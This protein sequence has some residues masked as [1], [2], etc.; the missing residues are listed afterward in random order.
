ME[1]DA[2]VAPEG[3]AEAAVFEPRAALPMR[4]RSGDG[5]RN[6]G[7]IGEGRNVERMTERLRTWG[8]E[9]DIGEIEVPLNRLFGC[10]PQSPQDGRD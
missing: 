2:Y 9:S 7:V 6:V 4:S 8:G 3:G 1:P 5:R 10:P